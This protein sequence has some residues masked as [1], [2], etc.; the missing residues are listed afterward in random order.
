[1][2]AELRQQVMQTE[3]QANTLEQA[4]RTS[5][6]H[7]L[8]KEKEI[9]DLKLAKIRSEG[10]S[11]EEREGQRLELDEA[12]RGRRSAEESVQHLQVT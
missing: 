12:Q 11:R 3:N 7:L 6:N 8:Q 10:L 4:L 9:S 2:I 1:M 5:Q